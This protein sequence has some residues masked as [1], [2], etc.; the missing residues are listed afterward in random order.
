MGYSDN[1]NDF[2][3][4]EMNS[5]KTR[6]TGGPGWVLQEF[7][8]SVNDGVALVRC[9]RFNPERKVRR[10]IE[11]EIDAKGRSTVVTDLE[12]TVS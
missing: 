12:G 6:N 9:V 5:L 3:H 8:H 10:T 11:Y 1:M 2:Q 4:A 7:G